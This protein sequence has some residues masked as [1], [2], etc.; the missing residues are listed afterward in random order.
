M[1]YQIEN[2][3]V[4]DIDKSVYR[5]VD[6]FAFVHDFTFSIILPRAKARKRAY[7]LPRMLLG[8]HSFLGS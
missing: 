5:V 7:Y 2:K 8:L 4:V 3:F 6:N 1:F